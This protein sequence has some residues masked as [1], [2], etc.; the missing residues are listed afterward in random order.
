MKRTISIVVLISVMLAGCGRKAP[1]AA[2]TGPFAAAVTAYLQQQGMGMKVGEFETLDVAGDAAT[3]VAAMQ[4]ADGLY[5][6]KVIWEF[7]FQKGSN[8]WR[9]VSHRTKAG[10]RK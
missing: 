7:S 3:A 9:I 6:M 4:D 10:G 5:K 2:D 1:S 8:G